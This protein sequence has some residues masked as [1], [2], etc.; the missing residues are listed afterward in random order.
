LLSRV[1]ILSLALSQ[2]PRRQKPGVDSLTPPPGDLAQPYDLPVGAEGDAKNLGYRS[3]SA[4]IQADAGFRDV[5]DKAFN[6]GRVRFRDQ[7][8]RPVI[9]DPFVVS[10]AKVISVSHDDTRLPDQPRWLDLRFGP[11]KNARLEKVF[12][13]LGRQRLREQEALQLMAT[14]RV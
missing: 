7:E 1:A 11:A 6:P 12:K 3:Q 10:A 14:F 4:D 5:E 9:I 13:C 2:L 8:A